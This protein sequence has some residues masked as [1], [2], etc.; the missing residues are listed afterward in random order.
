M[1]VI[2][3]AITAGP[4]IGHHY[5]IKGAFFSAATCESNYNHGYSPNLNTEKGEML[6]ESFQIR[7]LK[8]GLT[9]KALGFSQKR[10]SQ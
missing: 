9:L 3:P 1:S 5:I 4:R 8:T 10:L 6:R 2:R 7:K